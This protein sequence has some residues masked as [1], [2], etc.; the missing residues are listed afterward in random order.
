MCDADGRLLACNEGHNALISFPTTA[1]DC[2]TFTIGRQ[3]APA[4]AD[5]LMARRTATP[6]FDLM[7]RCVAEPVHKGIYIRDGRKILMR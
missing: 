6:T 5:S 2:Y 3:S 4:G 7:G 1:G